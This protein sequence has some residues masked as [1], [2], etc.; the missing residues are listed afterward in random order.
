MPHGQSERILTTLICTHRGH[1]RRSHLISR[2]AGFT[3]LELMIVV[4]VIVILSAAVGPSVADIVGERTMYSA[5]VQLQ[6]D[7][8]EVQ[9]M[10]AT[11]RVPASLVVT[12]ST[13]TFDR[14]GKAIVR[15]MPSMYSLAAVGYSGDMTFDAYGHPTVTYTPSTADASIHIR[16][17]GSGKEIAVNVSRVLGM[18]SITWVTR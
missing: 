2:T 4:G 17:S 7:L 11:T 1:L 6:Q 13:Y 10:A 9:Q 18:L 3:I 8:R 16:A 12:S 14:K 15:R 5:A